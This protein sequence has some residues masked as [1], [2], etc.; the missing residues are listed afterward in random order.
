MV[1]AYL[2]LGS[3]LGNKISN[4][5]QAIE[6]LDAAPGVRVVRVAPYYRTAPVGYT[7]QGFFINTVAEIETS[8]PPL[9]LLQ[10]SLGLEKVLGRVRGMRW[11]PRP[12]DIDLLLYGEEEINRP[13]LVIPHPCM[14][15]RAFVMVPLADL[16]PEIEIPGR[17]KVT[18]LAALLANKQLIE[19]IISYD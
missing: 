8:L 2:G 19:R 16:A 12:I 15:Q 18:G 10:L 9:H 5:N 13:E 11:G 14:H 7:R 6:L 1:I 4:I 3:N 17:G